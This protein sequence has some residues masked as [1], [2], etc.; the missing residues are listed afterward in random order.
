MNA[1]TEIV[2]LYGEI[3]AASALTA[4]EGLLCHDQD[5]EAGPVRLYISSP[6]GCVVNGFAVI[7]AMKHLRVPVQ[8]VGIGMVASMAAIVFASGTPGHRYLLPHARFMLHQVRGT[9]QGLTAALRSH[10]ALQGGFE[11]EIESV[12]AVCTRKSR[13]GVRRLLQREEFLA[14]PDV[15]ALGLADH[16]LE[17]AH[18]QA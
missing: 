12:L 17:G 13:A 11:H 6:G 9:A 5:P 16:V 3:T 18:E 1:G 14:P 15:V 8:T 4:I 2:R 10:A 7:D